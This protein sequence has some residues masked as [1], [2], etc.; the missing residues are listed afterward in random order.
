MERQVLEAIRDMIVSHR[1]LGLAVIVDGDAEASLLPYAIRPDFGAVYV[2]ASG[3]ARHSRGLQP[4]ARV[5]VLIHEAESQ[6]A[7]PLQTRRM[8]VQATV[9]VLDRNSDAYAAASAIFVARF[10]GAEMT[11]SLG[12]FTLYELPFGRGRYVAGFAQAFNLGPDTFKDI[13]ALKAH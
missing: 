10:P 5:G 4:G 2:Q 9:T 1:V 8:T 12:D 13:A 6:D 7:D 11:L 3:L